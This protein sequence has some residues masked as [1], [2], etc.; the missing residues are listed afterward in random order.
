[1]RA[2]QVSVFEGHYASTGTWAMFFQKSRAYRG[3]LL[4]RDPSV[5][6]RYVTIDVW[7]SRESYE[8][9]RKEHAAKY[10]EIDRLCAEFTVSEREIGMFELA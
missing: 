7:D 3:T 6:N 2:E 1:M 10:E 4:L 5:A 8:A 9:F